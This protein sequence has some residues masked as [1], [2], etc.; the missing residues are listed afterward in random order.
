MSG[1]NVLALTRDMARRNAE[2][3][4]LRGVHV[5][6]VC[7]DAERCALFAHALE[8]AGALVTTSHSA[9][10][11]A[12]VMDRLHANVIVVELRDGEARA[13][14][15]TALRAL[16]A[17]GGGK[18]PALALTRS[19]DDADAMLASGFQLHAA[20]PVRAAELCAAVATLAQ[21][22]GAWPQL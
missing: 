13:S 5:L 21:Q 20:M 22:S 1:G 6:V 7:D 15:I 8:Y 18:S 3:I 10:D 9:G 12:A 2:P 16:P 11:A 19:H 4:T 14:L 17:D